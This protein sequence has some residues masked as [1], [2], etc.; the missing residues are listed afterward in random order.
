MLSWAVGAHPAAATVWSL[1]GGACTVADPHCF[2]IQAAV[3]AASGGDTIQIGA[4]THFVN[5]TVDK[6]L[7]LQGAG[8]ATTVLNGQ[9]RNPV[10]IVTEDAT[11]HLND[12]KLYNGLALLLCPHCASAGGGL[13]NF[14]TAYLTRCDITGNQVPTDEDGFGVGVYSNNVLSLQSC[15]VRDNTGMGGGGIL[16]DRG[17]MTITDSLISDNR[18]AFGAGILNQPINSGKPPMGA[19]T[20]V[21]S[22]IKNNHPLQGAMGPGGGIDTEGNTTIEDS[23]FSNNY[24]YSG[25]ALSIGGQSVVRRCT[26]ADNRA[27]GEHGNGGAL[28]GFGYIGPITVEDCTFYGNRAQEKGGAI[29]AQLGPFVVI[30]STIVGNSAGVN[31]G[32]IAAG[33]FFGS[34]AHLDL[35]NTTL[36]RSYGQGAALYNSQE[37]PSN[38]ITLKNTLIAE[39]TRNSCGGIAPTSLGHNLSGDDTC[40]LTGTGD[41]P[42]TSALPLGSLRNNGGPTF[43]CALLPGSPAIDAGDNTD[44]PST[45]QRGLPRIADGDG[46]GSLLADI[47][48][49]ERQKEEPDTI[50]PT[51]TRLESG[52]DTQGFAYLDV[53]FQ[54]AE[55][56]LQSIQAVHLLNAAVG[57]ISFTPGTT[58]PVIVRFTSTS[59]TQG[60]SIIVRATDVAGNVR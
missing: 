20:V 16:N 18:A 6:N 23:V 47:G 14:G 26:F 29:F 11:V 13:L 44:A 42:N 24:A 55:S 39:G 34:P 3:N 58:A 27:T 40:G 45:D 4:G 22:V 37:N 30:N 1:S 10:V 25:G 35:I 54:D 9:A 36:S 32:A 17:T 53:Q 7:T 8:E 38:V 51:I 31:G 57:P 12:L 41:L 59:K 50:P 49:Y 60:S 48:A 33:D 52:R 56:G 15:T 2:G 28:A 21:R 5:V 43:T 19:L 46:N